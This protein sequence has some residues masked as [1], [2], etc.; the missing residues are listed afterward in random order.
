MLKIVSESSETAAEF[1]TVVK[2]GLTLEEIEQDLVKKI[3]PVV[4]AMIK[5]SLA[6]RIF[7]TPGLK[8]RSNI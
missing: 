5:T 1:Q 4:V 3:V 2:H 7:K 8:C 6:K